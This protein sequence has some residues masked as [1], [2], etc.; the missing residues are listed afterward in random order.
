M[1]DSSRSLTAASSGFVSLFEQ[2]GL[3]TVAFEDPGRAQESR[4]PLYPARVL[5]KPIVSDFLRTAREQVAALS[6]AE[7]AI[8]V[9]PRR[10]TLSVPLKRAVGQAPSPGPKGSTGRWHRG[11][12]VCGA[13]IP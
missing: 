13:R 6:S 9:G 12:E 1:R 5:E 11:D 8:A 2:F 3:T 7:L 10:R 4:A